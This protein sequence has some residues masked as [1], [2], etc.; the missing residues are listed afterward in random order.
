MKSE[1]RAEGWR[2]ATTR[3]MQQ[4]SAAR[5]LAGVGHVKDAIRLLLG[6][7]LL[8]GREIRRRVHE[9]AIGL[10]DNHRLALAFASLVT[11]EEDALRAIRLLEQPRLLERGHD[12]RKAPIVVRLAA[13]L[14]AHVDVEQRVDLLEGLLALVAQQLPRAQ[15]A[16]V[17]RLQRHHR[18]AGSVLE[19]LVRIE[20]HLREGE[21]TA[22]GRCENGERGVCEKAREG[23]RRR[24]DGERGRERVCEGV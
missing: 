6:H 3:G 18:L 17:A 13:G 22:R 14:E 16:L 2:A 20:A 19:D 12:A 1:G 5:H 11:V 23:E 21:R 9:A 24:E 10:L 4:R 15:R 8:H 7:P